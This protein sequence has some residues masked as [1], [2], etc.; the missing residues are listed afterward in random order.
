[1]IHPVNEDRASRYHRLKRRAA[2]VWTF[3]GGASL[4]GFV[5]AGGSRLLR[6]EAVAI[7]AAGP[8]APSTVAVY[9]LALA[10]AYLG[11]RLP[12][13]FY[14]GYVLERRYGLSS[15]T[16]RA[17]GLDYVKAAALTV[18][19]GVGAAQ[20]V[21]LTLRWWPAWWWIP[22]AACLAAALVVLARLVPVALL[23]L[24]YRLEPLERESL[25]ARLADL[26]DRARVPVLGIHVW[27][28]GARTRRANAALVGSGATRRILVSDTLL[29]DYS[30]D[31]I[32]VILAHEIAHHV[33][34]DIRRALLVESGLVAA[35]LGAGALALARWWP[36]VGLADPSDVA[37]LPLLILAG[38][39]V[40]LAA[41]PAVNALSRQSERRADRYALALTGRPDAFARAMRRLAAQNLAEERPSRLAVWLFHSH[42]PFGERIERAKEHVQVGPT[43]P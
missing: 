21:Y 17:W 2:L 43:G 26:C 35:S 24:F 20:I 25:H 22:S 13:A 40:S 31:E 10:L 4:F 12:L 8:S 5:M 27:G 37:G 19:L 3:A 36:A 32:E 23:P 18:V 28:L 11:L 33:H 6:D 16:L 29:A 41:A 39:A 30:E 42:P 34:G 38:L 9:A 15:E 1:M 14:Q 7:T